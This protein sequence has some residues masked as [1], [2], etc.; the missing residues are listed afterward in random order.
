MLDEF[1]DIYN[2]IDQDY[3][4]QR[5]RVPRIFPRPALLEIA[6]IVVNEALSEALQDLPQRSRV[7]PDAVHL[8][9]VNLH[10]MVTLPLFR[11]EEISGQTTLHPG[12][13]KDDL[14]HDAGMV[15]RESP[16][17]SRGEITGHAVIDTMSRIWSRLRITGFEV[18][19]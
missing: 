4:E 18:W 3:A 12:E 13:L 9:R 5:E 17:D 1:Y 19:G 11:R 7:R 2:D 14:R 6:L 15:L 8:L 16:L 10:Q